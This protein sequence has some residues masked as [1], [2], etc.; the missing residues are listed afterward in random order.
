[1][2][3]TSA[4]CATVQPA[5]IERK[6]RTD[7]LDEDVLQQAAKHFNFEVFKFLLSVRSTVLASLDCRLI[8]YMVFINQIKAAKYLLKNFPYLATTFYVNLVAN[9]NLA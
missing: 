4:S 6:F 7:V 2:V 1:M 3:I 5:G 8:Y 9:L